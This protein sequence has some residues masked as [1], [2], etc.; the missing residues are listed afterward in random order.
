M[1]II[2]TFPTISTCFRD[3]RFSLDAW[4]A[5]AAHIDP[6]LPHICLEDIRAYDFPTQVLPVLQAYYAR[7][8]Q[9]RQA[10]EA[11][12]LHT[13]TMEEKLT[14]IHLPVDA[15]VILYLGLCSG[16]G[17][18]LTL[19]DE[20]VVLLGLEKIL[21]LGWQDEA[22]MAAL[23]DHELGH[24]WH[25]QHRSAPPFPS[26][27][28]WQLYT[29]GM[30]MYFE[31]RLAGDAKY[32][33]QNKNGWLPW[34]EANRDA[35]LTEYLRR[36]NANESVQ[37]FFGDWCSYQDHSDVGYYLGSALVWQLA[38]SRSPEQL[39]ELSQEE[40]LSVFSR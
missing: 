3:G 40:F 26:P 31:Q 7:P 30:A 21:E 22:A 35:L 24:L 29:E 27:A 18:A 38:Q 2:D 12:L 14:R 11:F 34:C 16:A 17:W 4:R 25:D 19:H 13:R 6:D 36:A 15:T 37:D 32:F 28:L 23:I 9:A 5:Y 10:H 33:H 39:A 20:P 8:D 1:R